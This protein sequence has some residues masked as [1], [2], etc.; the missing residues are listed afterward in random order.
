[1]PQ[2]FA[3]VLS[4]VPKSRQLSASLA[5]AHDYARAQGHRTVT[6]E[7]LLLALTDD[8]DAAAVL[9]ASRVPTQRMAKEVSTYLAK[10]PNTQATEP[11][12]DTDLVRILDYAVA[13]AQQS[14]RR[15]VNG[16]IVLAALVG[17]GRS[18]A[19]GILRSHGLT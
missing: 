6:L 5:R 16:A 19:A 18:A 8:P 1:M 9:K 12:A 17:E 15:E 14:R 2:S 10:L 11:E 4:W 7:H 13:A 3:D